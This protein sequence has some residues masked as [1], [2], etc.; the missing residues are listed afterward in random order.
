MRADLSAYVAYNVFCRRRQPTLRCAVRQD[1]P[2][3]SFV[4]DE[5]WGFGGTITIEEPSAG[6]QPEA[7]EDAMR[8]TGY[9][10]FQTL[11]E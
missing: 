9:Y 5:T 11:E 10:L 6:F 8:F 3:P 1:R 2:V 7:V 4:R